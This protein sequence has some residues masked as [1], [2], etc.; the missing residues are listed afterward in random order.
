MIPNLNLT[1]T[2]LDVFNAILKVLSRGVAERGY[3]RVWLVLVPC[4]FNR[5][6]KGPILGYIGRFKVHEIFHQNISPLQT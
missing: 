3:N 2:R 4:V 1:T 5:Q 6:G